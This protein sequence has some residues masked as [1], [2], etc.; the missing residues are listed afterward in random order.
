MKD[1]LSLKTTPWCGLKWKVVFLSGE[2]KH[3]LWAASHENGVIFISSKL[4]W[5]L[6]SICSIKL[7]EPLNSLC[8]TDTYTSVHWVVTGASNG[9]LLKHLAIKHQAIIRTNADLLTNFSKI[10]MK[11]L[12]F[13]FKNSSENASHFVQSRLW[14]AGTRVLMTNI[15]VA[16]NRQDRNR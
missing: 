12:T 7:I 9:L 16:S 3:N 8:P 1:H 11:Y 15:N 6:P 2:N 13:S 4:C 10:Q 5:F 14:W